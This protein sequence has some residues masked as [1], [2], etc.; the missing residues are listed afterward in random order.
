[1]GRLAARLFMALV[2]LSLL[3]FYGIA[4]VVVYEFLVAVWA[5]RPPLP[6]AVA[7]VLVITVSFGYLSYRFG[8]NRMLSNLDAARLPRERAPGVHE[9]VDRLV[10]QMDLDRPDV[11]VAQMAAPNALALGGTGN[12]V[13]VLDAELFRLLDADELETIVAHELAHLEGYDSLIQTLAF[14]AVRTVVGLFV[15]VLFPL[16]LLVGGVAR[17]VAWIRGRPFD[18]RNL[19]ARFRRGIGRL[20]V[21]VFVGLTLLVRAHSRRREY[22]ADDRAVEVTGKPRALAQALAKIKRA[23]EAPWGLLSPLYTHGNEE[24]TL[25]RMLSTHPPIEERV[26]RLREKAEANSHRIEVQ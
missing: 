15:L 21:L 26:E 14:S 25:T 8:T 22:A 19:A 12:G 13:L 10:E 20:V 18:R 9:M 3:A 7:I 5:A 17:A 23:S 4:A 1:M 2:G 16:L 6:T 24:G 11:L